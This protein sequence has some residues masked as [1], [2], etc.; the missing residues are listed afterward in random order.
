MVGNVVVYSGGIVSQVKYSQ[1]MLNYVKQTLD[2][3][4]LFHVHNN[5]K[6]N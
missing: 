3:H 6:L 5:K 2:V 4:K 1:I